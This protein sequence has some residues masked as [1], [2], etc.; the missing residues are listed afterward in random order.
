M[1]NGVAGLDLPFQPRR[2]MEIG[3]PFFAIA[4]VSAFPEAAIASIA[5]IPGDARLHSLNTLPWRQISG[6]HHA[7]GPEGMRLSESTDP[8]TGADRLVP[9][10]QGR[11][12]AVSLDRVFKALGWTEADLLLV[13]ASL[14]PAFADPAA[15]DAFTRFRRIVVRASGRGIAEAD[16]AARFPAA[17]HR[18]VQRGGDVTIDRLAPGVWYPRQPIPVFDLAGE[19][20]DAVLPAATCYAPIGDTGF[21]LRPARGRGRTTR[22]TV[23]RFIAGLDRF[24]CGLRMPPNPGPPLACAIGFVA[25]ETNRTIHRAEIELHA[26]EAHHW[27]FDLPAFFGEMRIEFEVA[28]TAEGEP[29]WLEIRDPRLL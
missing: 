28:P 26:A 2:I 6:I 8:E 14:C 22:L 19:R 27:R 4:L 20:L 24:E 10:P 11:L 21:R 16:L 1:E 15:G 18:I 5:P 29:G 3:L 17:T 12:S 7:I 13:D 23:T 9:D 25:S